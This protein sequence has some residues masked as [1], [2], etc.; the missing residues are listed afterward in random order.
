MFCAWERHDDGDA[1]L[2]NWRL[3]FCVNETL[4]GARGHP[5]ANSPALKKIGFNRTSA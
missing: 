3:G 4:V 5:I 1:V 2:K